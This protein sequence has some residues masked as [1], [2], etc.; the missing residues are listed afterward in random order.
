MGR[1]AALGFTD[2]ITHWPRDDE[3]YQGTRDVLEEVARDV[4]PGLR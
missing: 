1:A 4:M 2:V 3:P